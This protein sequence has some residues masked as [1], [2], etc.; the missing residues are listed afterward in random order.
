MKRHGGPELPGYF[1]L[2]KTYLHIGE[3]KARMAEGRSGRAA[4]EMGPGDRVGD[5][6]AGDR[7]PNAAEDLA[8]YL[9]GAGAAK[10]GEV[11]ERR[12]R[13]GTG[14]ARIHKRIFLLNPSQRLTADDLI[15]QIGVG[16]QC[17]GVGAV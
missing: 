8:D 1:W 6:A 13:W 7:E 3:M 12:L 15:V 9:H 17:S 16:R 11:K 10:S 14:A 5:I 2:E 4:G